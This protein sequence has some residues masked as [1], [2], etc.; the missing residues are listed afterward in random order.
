[1]SG[2]K[3]FVSVFISVLMLVSVCCFASSED[4]L[5][6]EEKEI[7]KLIQTYLASL[8]S[9][10]ETYET[11]FDRYKENEVSKAEQKAGM[12]ASYSIDDN[13]MPDVDYFLIKMTEPTLAEFAKEEAADYNSACYYLNDDEFDLGYEE[14]IYPALEYFDNVPYITLTILTQ[15]DEK[16]VFETVLYFKTSTVP[17]GDSGKS[18]CI[19]IGFKRGNY[20]ERNAIA[21][22]QYDYDEKDNNTG[23]NYNIPL[24]N[25]VVYQGAFDTYEDFLDRV[26]KECEDENMKMSLV[27]VAN[28]QML[29]LDAVDKEGVYRI[30]YWFYDGKNGYTVMFELPSS[31]FG[32][33]RPI[34]H[35]IH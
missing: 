19:P 25:I 29:K 33:I 8:V 31:D 32:F 35:S 18:M 27:T 16:Y 14:Y 15:L 34:V 13:N 5:S 1:M 21:C 26:F 17:I 11:I 4:A 23:V 10:E 2:F 3:K 30:E 12:I 24:G 7:A 6:K 20:D 22:Y 28:Q 9:E